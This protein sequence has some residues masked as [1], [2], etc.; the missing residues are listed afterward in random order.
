[1]I[2]ILEKGKY[3]IE[4]AVFMEVLL[5]PGIISVK[6]AHRKL[7]VGEIWHKISLF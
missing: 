4:R 6:N 2:Q 3:A 7:F 1:M 5:Y